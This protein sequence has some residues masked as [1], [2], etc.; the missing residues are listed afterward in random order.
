MSKKE[1]TAQ[2]KLFIDEYLKLR[3][4]NQKKTAMNAGYSKKSAEA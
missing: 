3:R 1:T 4:S 2:R